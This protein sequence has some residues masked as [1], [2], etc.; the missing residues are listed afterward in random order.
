MALFNLNNEEVDQNLRTT[1]TQLLLLTAGQATYR[2]NP[3]IISPT[4][5]RLLLGGVQVK[6]ISFA[7][8]PPYRTPLLIKCCVYANPFE[9]SSPGVQQSMSRV[10]LL[11]QSISESTSMAMVEHAQA[12]KQLGKPNKD[13]NYFWLEWMQVNFLPHLKLLDTHVQLN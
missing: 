1:G 5:S 6:M 3:A 12:E 13:Q 7:R 9:K 11:K 2:V 10:N 4:K 8:E